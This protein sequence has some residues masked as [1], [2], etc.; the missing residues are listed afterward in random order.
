MDIYTSI[1]FFKPKCP[2]TPVFS[3]KELGK[4]KVDWV[5][6]Q[7]RRMT[8]YEK[9]PAERVF[10][11]RIGGFRYHYI[12][13][14]YFAFREKGI[15]DKAYFLDYYVPALHIAF[16]ID[17]KKD[18]YK[19]EMECR[20]WLRD[21]DFW[22][23]LRIKTIRF[24]AHEVNLA[25]FRSKVFE[26]R[27]RAFFD[28]GDNYDPDAIYY[29]INKCNRFTGKETFNQKMLKTAIN[30]VSKAPV[31]SAIVIQTPQTYLMRVLDHE[32]GAYE[33]NLNQDLINE[34]CRIR[35]ERRIRVFLQF[36]GNRQNLKPFFL[37]VF[38]Y[39]DKLIAEQ[40]KK[41]PTIFINGQPPQNSKR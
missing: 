14:A 4:G 13:Q 28:Q 7:I 18:H 17:G 15:K 27:V 25:N 29:S 24:T 21:F 40:P 23:Y 33:S 2:Y 35:N 10:E 12:T 30:A 5:D 34:Y 38:A 31:G 32:D 26:P 6:E 11:Q 20:D 41:L 39:Y 8:I 22:N 3:Y 37:G 36:T 19:D 9:S 16:E 1:P